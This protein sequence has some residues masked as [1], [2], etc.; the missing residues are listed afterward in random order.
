MYKVYKN[1]NLYQVDFSSGYGYIQEIGE[2]EERFGAED[3]IKGSGN[4]TSTEYFAAVYERSFPKELSS[5]RE[6]SAEKY[7]IGHFTESPTQQTKLT[8]NMGLG[9]T[10]VPPRKTSRGFEYEYDPYRDGQTG[11]LKKTHIYVKLLGNYPVPSGIEIPKYFRDDEYNFMTGT[12][13]W[14]VLKPHHQ[15]IKQQKTVKN[16]ENLPPY[17]LGFGRCVGW[18]ERGMALGDWNDEYCLKVIEERYV[19]FP[20]ERP[21][22]LSFNEVA[23]TIPTKGWREN[24]PNTERAEWY[25]KIERVLQQFIIT[26]SSEEKIQL[27]Q[28]KKAVKELTIKLNEL[29]N[30]EFFIE[31]VERED[32]FTFISNLLRVKKVHSAIDVL[33]EYRDW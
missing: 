33:D 6:L 15:F 8:L 19:D 12:Y 26:L 21:I 23:V 16:I 5:V 13:K 30:D 3:E 27:R 18:W 22:N 2:T 17:N 32:L 10:M 11:E 28:A 24:H 1:G 29:Q 20:E 31:T 25:T 9:E 14:N 4:G 7:F